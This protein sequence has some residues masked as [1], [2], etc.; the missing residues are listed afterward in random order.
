VTVKCQVDCTE[1]SKAAKRLI[2]RL[3]RLISISGVQKWNNLLKEKE[4][5]IDV[6]PGH[7]S[8]KDLDIMI[9]DLSLFEE[10]DDDEDNLVLLLKVPHPEDIK[11]ASAMLPSHQ[12]DLIQITYQLEVNLQLKGFG[13]SKSDIPAVLPLTL[14][15]DSNVEASPFLLK[16]LSLNSLPNPESTIITEDWTP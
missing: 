14:L 8:E 10:D 16:R 5:K 12:S 3:R 13:L 9:E 15:P 11:E 1:S 7:T 6:A 4:Y 2:L